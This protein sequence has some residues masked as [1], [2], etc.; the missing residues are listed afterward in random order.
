MADITDAMLAKYA[1]MTW[2]IV[3]A[4]R[5]QA[6]SPAASPAPTATTQ[7]SAGPLPW[8]GAAT[9]K[10]SDEEDEREK[11]ANDPSVADDE[12]ARGLI[13][14]PA[15][16]LA[17]AREL[18]EMARRMAAG[19]RR[20]GTI[21]SAVAPQRASENMQSA[22]ALAEQRD[23]ID[24]KMGTGRWAQDAERGSTFDSRSQIQRFGVT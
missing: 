13:R 2:A 11:L 3:Q 17:D 10:A 20:P 19:Y 9:P 23:F 18:V 14:D 21:G 8:F 16:S 5:A 12:R 4:R 22:R 7:A 15:V 1:P 24:S 6:A